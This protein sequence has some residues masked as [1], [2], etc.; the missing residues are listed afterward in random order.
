MEAAV[1]L[2]LPAKGQQLSALEE[3]HLAAPRHDL[4]KVTVN[5]P[6][7]EPRVCDS[8]LSVAATTSQPGSHSSAAHQERNDA[9]K[10]LMLAAEEEQLLHSD[11][12]DPASSAV[13]DD[14]AT[15]MAVVSGLTPGMHQSC[16]CLEGTT[17]SDL[18][19]GEVSEAQPS[20]VMALTS[21][22][23]AAES[24]GADSQG[25]SSVGEHDS[26]RSRHMQAARMCTSRRASTSEVQHAGGSVAASR[27]ISDV[28]VASSVAAQPQ[29]PAAEQPKIIQAPLPAATPEAAAE[30]SKPSM[31][32][33]LQPTLV[34]TSHAA[35]LSSAHAPPAYGSTDL[36]LPKNLSTGLPTQND[37]WQARAGG[38]TE[39]QD[40]GASTSL[41]PGCE[42]P[43][44]IAGTDTAEADSMAQDTA[45]TALV[46]GRSQSLQ[47]SQSPLCSS[48]SR[49]DPGRL[50]PAGSSGSPCEG[51]G[52]SRS[53][54]VAGTD[55]R[56][57]TLE[58]H[59]SSGG[60]T[61]AGHGATLM[62]SAASSSMQAGDGRSQVSTSGRVAG[63]SHGNCGA[64]ISMG[65]AGTDPA[66][67]VLM[68]EHPG[69]QPWPNAAGAL[70][71]KLTDGR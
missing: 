32:T 48:S 51:G 59:E 2:A 30:P 11:I 61:D 43:G 65:D 29:V 67:L 40:D 63:E 33:H 1:A 13:L 28:P 10:D 37:P 15:H 70:F 46:R 34:Y 3:A 4:P 60:C 26:S 68:Q 9:L 8:T 39:R 64:D 16:V 38:P 14:T 22:V 31:H 66:V 7:G 58:G 23:S 21:E 25:M 6:K 56:L 35:V 20:L 12:L 62:R 57:H 44:D 5:S 52:R 69:M 54:A 45:S 47:H 41:A 42:A 24:L 36:Q 71:H 53:G 18:E 27:A 49:P 55:Q 50:R 17:Q 19:L